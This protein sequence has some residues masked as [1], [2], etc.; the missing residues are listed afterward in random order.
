MEEMN[1]FK[2]IHFSGQIYQI[3]DAAVLLKSLAT[4]ELVRIQEKFHPRIFD[5]VH[6]G[7]WQQSSRLSKL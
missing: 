1:I 2:Y 7:L 6:M 3:Y 4:P 5:P